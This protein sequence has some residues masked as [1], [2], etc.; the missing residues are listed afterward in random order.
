VWVK[1]LREIVRARSR[2]EKS[3]LFWTNAHRFYA[4]ERTSTEY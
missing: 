4:L 3:K 1:L 2:E